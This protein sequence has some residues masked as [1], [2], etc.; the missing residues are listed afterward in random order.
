VLFSQSVGQLI[1][2]GV[3]CVEVGFQCKL[4]LKA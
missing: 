3:K 4:P 1:F 2:V